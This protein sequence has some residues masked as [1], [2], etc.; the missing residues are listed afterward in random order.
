MARGSRGRRRSRILQ[1]RA[2]ALLT[3]A[4]TLSAVSSAIAARTDP[5]VDLTT[6]VPADKPS[7]PPK[8]TKPPKPSPSPEPSPEP[9]PSSEPS[10]E[11]SPDPTSSP[12]PTPSPAPDPATTSPPGTSAAPPGDPTASG[13]GPRQG[14]DTSL[15]SGDVPPSSL[16]AAL[17]LFGGSADRGPRDGTGSLFA[18]VGSIIHELS[19]DE[20]AIR[21]AEALCPGS[22]CGSST[23]D[24]TASGAPF[25]VLICLAIAIAGALVVIRAISPRST[26]RGNYPHHR[27]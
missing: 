14:G 23:T 26:T 12:A 4:L 3:I 7:K 13:G 17:D 8:P 27:P 25:I 18:T 1:A 19:S 5:S 22:T 20:G 21:G 2:V 15:G 6:Q 9:S 11:P 10:Q 24:A 16:V